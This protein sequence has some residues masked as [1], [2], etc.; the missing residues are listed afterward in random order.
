[1]EKII[2]IIA[3]KPY[4]TAIGWAATM[5]ALILAIITPILQKKRQLLYY[6]FS[7]SSIVN[8]QQFKLPNLSVKYE[9]RDIDQLSVTQIQIWNAG[10]TSI[11]AQDMFHGHELFV[12]EKDDTS[13]DFLFS[14]V[15][16]QSSDT[17]QCDRECMKNGIK[18]KFQTFERGDTIVVNIYHTGK[19][20]TPLI[21]DGKIRE[22][23]IFMK[24][25]RVRYSRHT[26]LKKR[27][28]LLVIIVF[29]FFSIVGIVEKNVNEAIVLFVCS[30]GMIIMAS[31]DSDWWPS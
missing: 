22:G 28:A 5:L 29:L 30:I 11:D 2:N 3:T 7:S 18:I 27:A 31:F 23:N 19:R 25:G 9:S 8:L 21:L 24:D 20:R 10:N 14:E 17:I 1:M 26:L 12:K 13:A 4:L 16:F 15:S 6:T